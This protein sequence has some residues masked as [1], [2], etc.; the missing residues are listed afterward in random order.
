MAADKK[1]T[2]KKLDKD[3]EVIKSLMPAYQD[4]PK[5][6][7]VFRD[8]FPVLLDPVASEMLFTRLVHRVQSAYGRVDLII[9]LE[10][11]GFLFGPVMATRLGGVLLLLCLALSLL[12]FAAGFVPIRK[13]GKLPGV[14]VK[15]TYEKEYGKV[16]LRWCVLALRCGVAGYR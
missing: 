14:V 6:G 12:V 3:L 16:R 11:R 9:G 5:K 7:V 13:D 15:S 2:E 10:T 8:I 4:F 1:T